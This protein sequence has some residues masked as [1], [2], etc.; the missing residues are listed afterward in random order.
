MKS[1]TLQEQYVLLAAYTLQNNAYLITIREHLKQLTGTDYAI[2][3]IYAPL[4]RLWK[5][6]YLDTVI[7]KPSPKVGGRWIK[8]YRITQDGIR[9]LQK[10]KKLHDKMWLDFTETPVTE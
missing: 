2:G 5:L 6:G 1:L 4:D 7:E 3:T 9:A 10:M 8:Y